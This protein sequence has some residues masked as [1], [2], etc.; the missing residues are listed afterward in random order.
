MFDDRIVLRAV[1]QDLRVADEATIPVGG[2]LSSE[3]RAAH[4]TTRSV[5][6]MSLRRDDAG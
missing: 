4:S 6:G 3:T 1:N 5:D 2:E